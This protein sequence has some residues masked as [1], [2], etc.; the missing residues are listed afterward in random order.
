MIRSL[1]A[2]GYPV[3]VLRR[4]AVNTKI[5]SSRGRDFPTQALAV[6]MAVVNRPSGGA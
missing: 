3:S 2:L 1:S 6:E 5:G 4:A